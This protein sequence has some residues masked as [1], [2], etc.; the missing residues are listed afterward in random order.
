[1][2]ELSV[3][4]NI[5]EIVREHTPEGAVSQV[6]EVLVRVG[7]LSGVVPD[8]LQFCFEA[9]TSGTDLAGAAMRIDRVPARLRCRDC[10]MEGSAGEGILLC[11]GCGSLHTELTQ[12]TELQVVS[13]ELTEAAA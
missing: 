2:H 3:A 6:R 8:S 1:M 4:A 5:I 10:G 11:P 12:G 13:I 7:D 9:V